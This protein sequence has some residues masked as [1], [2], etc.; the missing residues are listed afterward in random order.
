MALS[1]AELHALVEEYFDYP[2]MLF[3]IWC[4]VRHRKSQ[5]AKILCSIIELILDRDPGFRP[6]PRT[7]APIGLGQL[8]IIKGPPQGILKAMGYK[9]GKNGESPTVRRSR[10]SRVMEARDL[11][12]VGPEDYMAEWANPNTCAR[13]R[14]IAHSIA[15]FARNAKRHREANKSQ[16]IADWEAD[17]E[18]LKK[19]YYVGQCDFSW[20]LTED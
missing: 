13:L 14:K 3:T 15:S 8:G 17:L 11:P 4:E 7:D 2:G 6:F 5:A 12:K 18:W 9:V 10:L 19:S 20:P 1:T 16:A